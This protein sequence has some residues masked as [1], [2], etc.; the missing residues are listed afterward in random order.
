MIDW[1]PDLTARS[2]PMYLAIADAIEDDI[3]RGRLASET[4]LPPQREL[5]RALAIDFTTV[6]RGYVEAQRRGL[7]ESRVGQ[8][9]FVAR[10]DRKPSADVLRFEELVDLSMNLPPEPDDPTLINRMQTGLEL[11]G[12]DLVAL[13]RYQTFGGTRN[14]KDAASTWLGR[15]ALVPSHDRLFITP[16]AHP[17][18]FGILSG[19]AKPGDH[20][21]CE[22]IT[23]PGV[24]AIAAQQRLVLIR[25]GKAGGSRGV[26]GHYL[27]RGQGNR[28]ATEAGADRDSNGCRRH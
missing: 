22:A 2:K 17:A 4:R 15:R 9:T 5:A 10:Q 21:A 19:L 6:A 12:E 28:S 18:L 1:M 8:G 27:S 7:I 23:Y 13:L 11:V 25:A 14:A 26:R 24:K 20:V 16:G 3:R